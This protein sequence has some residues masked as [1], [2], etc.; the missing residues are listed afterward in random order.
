MSRNLKILHTS[1]LYQRIVDDV[2]VAQQLVSAVVARGANERLTKQ[3][4]GSFSGTFLHLLDTCQRVLKLLENISNL[5]TIRLVRLDVANIRERFLVLLY[6]VEQ[7]FGRGN[8]INGRCQLVNQ[9]AQRLD[10][11]LQHELFLI[12]ECLV[13]ERCYDEWIAVSIAT[14]KTRLLARQ[15]TILSYLSKCQM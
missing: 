4:L 15:I 10:I 7:L 3:W 12:D 13:R 8:V 14:L 1:I 11:S 9:V 2:N 6:G 5:A